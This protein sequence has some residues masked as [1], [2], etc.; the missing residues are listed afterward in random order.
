MPASM[1]MRLEPGT[2]LMKATPAMEG[3]HR[4]IYM[5]ASNEARDIQAEKTLASALEE[6]KDYFLR[7]GRIDLDHATMTQFIRDMK[8][9]PGNPYAREIGTPL[10]VKISR[11]NDDMPR[12]WVKA[13][14]FSSRNKDNH[15]TKAADWFWDSLNC[16]PPLKWYPSIGGTL[17]K[18]A[19]EIDPMTNQPTRVLTKL[20]WHSIGLSRTPVNT[21]VSE[22]SMVPLREFAKAMTDQGHTFAEMLT[23]L[24]LPAA[25]LVGSQQVSDLGVFIP[26]PSA[27]PMPSELSAEK[28]QVLENIIVSSLPGTSTQVYVDRAAQNGISPAAALAFLVA[29]CESGHHLS[30]SPNAGENRGDLSYLLH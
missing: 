21:A 14:I 8:L 11:E 23:A 3:G 17:F 24:G 4:V 30:L 13:A 16:T 1:P 22:I 27:G 28:A 10:D 18:D 29:I 7:H 26:P 2:Q 5:E 20:R 9:E 19:R 12:V 25:D 15:F 6:S